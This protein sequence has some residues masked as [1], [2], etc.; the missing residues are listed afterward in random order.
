MIVGYEL[1]L[2]VVFFWLAAQITILSKI[3]PNNSKLTCEYS[4]LRTGHDLS[5]MSPVILI[6]TDR[7]PTS[8]RGNADGLLGIQTSGKT[9]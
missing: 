8:P 6:I 4:S 3:P 2:I 7:H 5:H 1:A 9:D